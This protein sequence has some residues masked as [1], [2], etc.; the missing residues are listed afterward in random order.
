MEVTHIYFEDN[1][2]VLNTLEEM[3]R[4]PALKFGYKQ[5]NGMCPNL[6][7]RDE[8]PFGIFGAPTGFQPEVEFN[9]VQV[10]V[11]YVAGDTR[12][13]SSS[14]VSRLYQSFCRLCRNS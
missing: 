4:I 8:A 13:E 11:P 1:M 5:F 7:E 14:S 12:S 2:K 6:C 9:A 3:R 10:G